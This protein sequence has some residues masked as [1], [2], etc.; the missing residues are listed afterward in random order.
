MFLLYII[1]LFYF[2][3]FLIMMVGFCCSLSLNKI[4]KDGL[5]PNLISI[6]ISVRNEY[7]RLDPL[8]KSLESQSISAENFELIFVDDHSSDNTIDK[9]KSWS[10]ESN[11]NIKILSLEQSKNGKKNALQKGIESAVGN[12]ILT[13]DADV[14]FSSDF[15]FSISFYTNKSRDLYFIPVLEN[16]K[17]NIFS[18]IE[19]YMLS[20]V[21]IGSA[22][23]NHPLLLNGAA[24]LFRKD[25]FI[26]LQPFS[27]N[28]HI[29]S[30]DDIFLLESF[31]KHNKSFEVI[32]PN[33][34]FVN[35]ESPMSYWQYLRRGIRWSGKMKFSKLHSTKFIGFLVLFTNYIVLGLIIFL[36]FKPSISLFIIIASKFFIDFIGL[37]LTVIIYRNSF[38]LLSS[39]L[40]LLFYP[41]HLLILFVCSFF[42]LQTNWKG[43]VLIEKK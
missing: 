41:F 24:M 28:N 30:G 37:L 29:L 36:M 18:K 4:K 17:G 43:R 6:I 22:K 25:C 32:S 11:V 39:P 27:N 31:I 23:L 19:S 7:N 16:Y 8:L 9:L 42:N 33:I 21:T 5:N 40:M 10:L 34:S 35:T 3:F 12:Y 20:L 15:I 26:E 14:S 38:L 2:I 1:L 13:L